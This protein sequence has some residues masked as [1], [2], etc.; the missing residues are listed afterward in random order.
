MPKT[1]IRLNSTQIKFL[2]F[3]RFTKI[4]KSIKQ[5]MPIIALHYNDKIM[6]CGL[7]LTDVLP[8]NILS[9]N[10]LTMKVQPHRHPTDSPRIIFPMSWEEKGAGSE[11][12]RTKEKKHEVTGDGAGTSAMPVHRWSKTWIWVFN[13]KFSVIIKTTEIDCLGE[14]IK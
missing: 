11:G 2:K 7:Y 1:S 3:Y 10:I 13:E 9:P 12:K 6:L 14:S 5:I 8:A 4:N